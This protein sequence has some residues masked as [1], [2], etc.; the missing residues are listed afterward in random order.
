VTLAEVVSAAVETAGPAVAKGGHVL[1]VSLPSTAVHLDA[2]L[3]RLAQVFGNLLVNSAKYTPQG[4]KIWL[5][6]ERKGAEVVVSVRDTSI[7][8]PPRALPAIFDMFSRVQRST[9]PAAGGLGIGL[10]LV[11][12]LVE[13]HGGTIAAASG[14]EGEGSTFTV[15][16]PV[17]DPSRRVPEA[18]RPG[19][20]T[21]AAGRRVLVV[22]DN[23]DGAES[24]AEM[25]RL[26][27]SE[28]KTAH[29][30][31]EAAEASEVFRPEVILMD[32]GMPRLD[33]LGATRLIRAQPW[34]GGITIVALTG[35]GREADR[36]L[37]KEAGCDG[38]LVK[39][40]SLAA[41]E[42]LLNELRPRQG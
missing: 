8:I 23:R 2:D 10:A 21:P 30:G 18:P 40:V 22:D 29:D 24:M 38:H 17:A 27:G 11:K 26:L 37:S 25:L 35:W 12:G 32:V 9:E 39:P 15:T 28:V 1:T 34:G 19:E 4:G 6:A 5:S 16:L 41:L 3:T 14:G 13:M 42:K 36:R 20:G 31:V 33:G 7:G